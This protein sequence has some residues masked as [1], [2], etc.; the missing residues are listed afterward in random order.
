MAQA[1][2]PVVG[3]LAPQVFPPQNVEAENLAGQDVAAPQEP[4]AAND[5]PAPLLGSLY[6]LAAVTPPT[7]EEINPIPLLGSLNGLVLIA[8]AAAQE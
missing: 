7:V 3:G 1:N 8:Q 2:L 5:G 4:A 6:G